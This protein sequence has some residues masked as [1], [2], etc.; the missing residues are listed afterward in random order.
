MWPFSKKPQPKP[1]R[2]I[3]PTAAQFRVLVDFSDTEQGRKSNYLK[4]QVYHIREGNKALW[5]KAAR[6]EKE[7]KIEMVQMATR[8]GG[9]AQMR[10]GGSVKVEG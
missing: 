10:L 3:R 1:Q 9:E 7:G 2:E 5:I 8:P 4:G 6:W